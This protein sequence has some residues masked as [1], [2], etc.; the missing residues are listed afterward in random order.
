M[1]LAR[2]LILLASIVLFCTGMAHLLGYSYVIPILTKSGVD[3]GIVSA[4]KGVWLTYSAHLVLLS[5]AVVWISRLSGTRSLLLFLV[6]FPV[7][8]AVVMCEFPAS[9]RDAS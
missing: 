3:S 5:V 7:A 2:W 4:L 1:T 6:L 8:D 9:V